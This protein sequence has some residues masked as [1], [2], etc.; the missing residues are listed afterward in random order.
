MESV[1]RHQHDLVAFL[2]SLRSLSTVLETV[3]DIDRYQLEADIVLDLMC[4]GRPLVEADESLEADAGEDGGG[5]TEAGGLRGQKSAL[6]L[7]KRKRRTHD[8][9]ADAVKV[10]EAAAADGEDGKKGGVDAGA[11]RGGHADDEPGRGAVVDGG[12][13]RSEALK[14]VLDLGLELGKGRQ[15]VPLVH[16][17]GRSDSRATP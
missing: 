15:R 9:L 10:A 12:R 6:L 17:L 16:C 5:E 11:G 7:N 3:L 13:D 8:A 4:S 14:K 1:R 2:I